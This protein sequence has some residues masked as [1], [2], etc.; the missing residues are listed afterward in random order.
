MSLSKAEK[1][2]LQGGEAERTG[3]LRKLY[4]S[5]MLNMSSVLMLREAKLMEYLRHYEGDTTLVTSLESRSMAV[6]GAS[7]FL[8]SPV[9]SAMID[10]FGCKAMMLFAALWSL[11][12]R[13][14]EMLLPTTKVLSATTALAAVSAS[15][16][17]AMMT[18]VGDLYPGDSAGAGAALAVMT[19]TRELGVLFGSLFGGP[20]AARSLRMAVS[21]S[22]LFA[23]AQVAVISQIVEKAPKKQR[24]PLTSEGILKAVNPFGFLRLFCNG[25]RLAMIATAYFCQAATEKMF[26]SSFLSMVFMERFGWDA[27]HRSRYFTLASAMTLPGCLVA[28]RLLLKLGARGALLFSAGMAALDNLLGSQAG[29]GRQQAAI[30]L[31]SLLQGAAQ[32]ASSVLMLEAG[33]AAGM[34]QAEIWGGI[35]SLMQ[36]AIFVAPAAWARW[37]GYCV[38]AK[39]HQR[40][41]TAVAAARVLQFSLAALL[42]RP[43]P[44]SPP[45]ASAGVAECVGDG[46]GQGKGQEQG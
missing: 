16:Q 38:R 27:V 11:G 18:S 35:T 37:Y 24:K 25:P 12:L 7:A 15:S 26:L 43:K 36:A 29:S 6:M 30:A 41:F 28:R 1:E 44:A 9:C 39:S 31:L 46:D 19:P 4:A 13:A 23:M 5:L 40:F 21:A 45:P 34:S 32:P 14:T 20:L 22:G 17:Q 3:A 2:A 10:S 33:T 8:I 42:P